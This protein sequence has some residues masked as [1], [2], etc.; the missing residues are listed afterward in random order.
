LLF[1]VGFLWEFRNAL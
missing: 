1:L